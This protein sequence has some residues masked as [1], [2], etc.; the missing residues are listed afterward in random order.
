M[1]LKIILQMLSVQT[2]SLRFRDFEV[3]KLS[4]HH[5]FLQCLQKTNLQ[6]S[7]AFCNRIKM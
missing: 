1:I 7:K 4:L 6:K 3:K 5:K 2:S